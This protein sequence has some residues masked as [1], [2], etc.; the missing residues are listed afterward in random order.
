MS[1]EGGPMNFTDEFFDVLGG[2]KARMPRY[3]AFSLKKPNSAQLGKKSRRPTEARI[4]KQMM[5]PFIRF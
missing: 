2:L 3:S 4:F 1:I 5:C